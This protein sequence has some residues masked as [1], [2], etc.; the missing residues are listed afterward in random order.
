[1]F[2]HSR[3][4]YTAYID[5]EE[6]CVWYTNSDSYFFLLQKHYPWKSHYTRI[7]FAVKFSNS[8]KTIFSIQEADIIILSITHRGEEIYG[9]YSIFISI[10]RITGN[11]RETSNEIKQIIKYFYCAVWS[12]AR[13]CNFVLCN[14]VCNTMSI[15]SWSRSIL[16]INQ[17][18]FM[19]S[20]SSVF[21]NVV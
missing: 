3:R 13:I 12:L 17:D 5:V 2:F 7:Y 10:F 9:V 21:N 14:M 19:F 8:I 1:M 16:H 20:V 6:K 4:S 15:S 18:S 11:N